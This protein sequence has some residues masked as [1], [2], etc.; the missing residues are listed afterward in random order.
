[1]DAYRGNWEEGLFFCGSNVGKIE[2][3][4]NVEEIFRDLFGD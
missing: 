4:E 3:M 1:V 2:K